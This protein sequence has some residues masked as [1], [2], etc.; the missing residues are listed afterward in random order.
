V[1]T[2]IFKGLIGLTLYQPDEYAAWQSDLAVYHDDYGDY[3]TNEPTMDGTASL[4]YLLSALENKSTPTPASPAGRLAKGRELKSV[5]HQAGF[6]NFT[7]QQGAIIRADSTAN[8]LTLVFTG[9]EYAEGL[10]FILQTLKKAQVKG[11]FFFTGDF[12][13]QYPAL[14][15]QTVA[16]GHYVGAHSNKH[17]LYADWKNRDST[18]VTKAQFQADLLDNYRALAP[19]GISLQSAPWFLPPYEWYNQQIA[20][21]CAELGVQLICH[22]PGT[23]SAADYTTTAD[24]NYRSSQAIVQSIG[25]KA[26]Q[27]GGLNGY[28]L[29]THV[30]A[31][32]LRT[33][34]LYLHWPH[35]LQVLQQNQYLVKPLPQ[36]LMQ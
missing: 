13:R 32:P 6:K 10:P 1:Y 18:L 30:G 9:H 8:K 21:W 4:I 3:S 24:A 11:A 26:A 27:P 7:T 31:G 29:L 12:V 19:F 16:E 23:L 5:D 2:S 15:K 14:V 28:L 36:L 35:L 22:T 34:K 25:S 20:D 33:D 17:L